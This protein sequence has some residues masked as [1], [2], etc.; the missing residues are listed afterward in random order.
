LDLGAP[1]S[2]MAEVDNYDPVKH[3]DVYP[4]GT[5]ITFQFPAKGDRGPVKLVWYDGT[6]RP[7]HPKDLEEGRKPH[8]NG[9]IVVGEEGSIIHGSHGAGAVRII[10]ETKMR[11]YE[12]PEETLPRVAGHHQD[13]L[14]AIREGR[15]AGSD[16]DY[17]G[18]LT[19]IG[20]L[21]LIAIRF[22]GTK[23]VWDA[24]KMRFDGCDE[25][26]QFV[27]PALREPW[28]L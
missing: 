10:P 13:W 20:L 25:A 9:A 19:E 3:V 17:G 24:E 14:Q 6:R 12:Q 21:G 11:A 22:P 7:P 18:P 28:E 8:G 2:V 1:T 15:P 27:R 4:S 26:N 16:F 5:A 23:L